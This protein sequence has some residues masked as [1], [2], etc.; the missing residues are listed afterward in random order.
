[1]REGKKP[2]VLGTVVTAAGATLRGMDMKKHGMTKRD[3]K[4]AIGAG[5]VGLGLAH[6][7]LGSIDLFQD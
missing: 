2:L 1:M 6:I 7:I 5:L 4:V 3:T